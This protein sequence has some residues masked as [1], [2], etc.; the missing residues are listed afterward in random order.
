MNRM[1]SF[2]IAIYL[3]VVLTACSQA[4]GGPALARLQINVSSNGAQ[5][6]PPECIRVPVLHGSRV[7]EQID[8][9]GQFVIG[10][11]AVPEQVSVSFHEVE[12]A[13]ALHRT[14]EADALRNGYAEELTLVSLD[15]VM[16]TVNL[17][18]VCQ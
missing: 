9:D 17:S 8:V 18:S 12:N 1:D 3:G 14:V 7:R 2:L 11:D 15:G 6:T 16:F 10:Y 4:A 13:G 5:V